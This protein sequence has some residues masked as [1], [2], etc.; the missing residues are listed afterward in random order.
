MDYFQKKYPIDRVFANPSTAPPSILHVWI[1][2]KEL[3][4]I[5]KEMLSLFDGKSREGKN[6]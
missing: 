2:L 1:L 5:Q 4:A 6:E 3:L